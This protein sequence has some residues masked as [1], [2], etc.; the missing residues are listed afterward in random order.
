M[1]I[2][3][4]RIRFKNYGDLVV[5]AIFAA[6][7]IYVMISGRNIMHTDA[8]LMVRGVAALMALSLVIIFKQE[9]IIQK[10]DD[11]PIEK[12]PFFTTKDECTKFIGFAILSAIYVAALPY[13]G[14]IISTLV[15]SIVSLFFLG[16]RGL[17]LLLIP[18]C[19]TASTYVMFRILLL[20]SLPV[21]VFG[22]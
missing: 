1:K 16:V 12:K 8:M 21:G 20:V 5:P 17:A 3:G 9:L 19:L 2:G 22:I 11:T 18:I 13:G 4:Y 7:L 6:V 15:F 14:F 10:V